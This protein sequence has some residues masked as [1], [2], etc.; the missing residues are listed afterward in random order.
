MY[1]CKYHRWYQ[2]NN[3]LALSGRSQGDDP[4]SHVSYKV[5]LSAG[6]I[7]SQPYH[8]EIVPVYLAANNFLI[9]KR[10][11]QVA[12]LPEVFANTNVSIESEITKKQTS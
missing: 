10:E 12:I 3:A 7:Y 5:D 6:T 8:R 9:L 2:R 4:I 11:D 1:A